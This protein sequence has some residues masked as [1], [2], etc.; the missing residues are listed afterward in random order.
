[1]F[2][3]LTNQPSKKR[4]KYCD[5]IMTSKKLLL[6]WCFNFNPLVPKG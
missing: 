6:W 4:I 5:N 2:L 1:M 3:W